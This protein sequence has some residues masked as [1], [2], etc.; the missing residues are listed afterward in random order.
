MGYGLTP[1]AF[2]PLDCAP[3]MLGSN[4]ET[5]VSLY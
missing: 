3:N 2:Q 1:L 5:F 4:I